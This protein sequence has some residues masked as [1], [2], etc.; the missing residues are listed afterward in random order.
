MTLG[1]ITKTDG[2]TQLCR[3]RG[4]R[5]LMLEKFSDQRGVLVVLGQKAVPLP[6]APKR[7][8]FTYDP[9]GMTRGQHSHRECAQVLFC[10][11]GA[12]KISVDDGENHE[13]FSLS[14]PN[15]ALYVPPM[16]WSEQFDHSPDSVLM[17]LASH[18]Y[19]ERDYIRDIDVWR[20][21]AIARR[22]A[23]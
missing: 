16:I 17:V 6:F 20:S 8:F 18:D 10:V 4:V 1:D 2:R 3:V 23:P 21:E 5:R 15:E 19:D 12:L 11:A 9:S 22:H 14:G 7:V 13:V